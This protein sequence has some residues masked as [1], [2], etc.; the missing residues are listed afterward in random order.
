MPSQIEIII[1]AVDKASAQIK[2]ISKQINNQSGDTKDLIKSFAGLAAGMGAVIGVGSMV[3]KTLVGAANEA[4]DYALAMNDLAKI[5]GMSV[6]ETSRLVQVADDYRIEAGAVANAMA[7]MVKKGFEPSIGALADLADKYRSIEDPNERAAELTKLLGRNW[8]ALIPLLEAGGDAIRENAKAIDESLVVTQ[9]SVNQAIEYKRA[10]DELNDTWLGLKVSVGSE[11]VPA[12]TSLVSAMNNVV[13]ATKEGQKAGLEARR[14][15]VEKTTASIRGNKEALDGLSQAEKEATETR[16]DEADAAKQLSDAVTDLTDVQ[17]SAI[18]MYEMQVHGIYNMIEAQ[19]DYAKSAQAAEDITRGNQAALKA[20]T[21]SLNE[22]NSAYMAMLG[23]QDTL[24][25]AMDEWSKT[26]GADAA[27]ALQDAGLSGERYRDA[28]AIIDEVLGTQ[29]GMQQDYND[30]LAELAEQ[31]AQGSLA[32]EDFRAQ[33]AAIR[34]EFAPLSERV[35]EAQERLNTLTSAFNYINGRH[36]TAYVDVIAT[37]REAGVG[38]GGSA[39]GS[40]PPGK[41]AGGGPV[42]AGVSYIVGE[43]GTELFVPASSGRI[44]PSSAGGGGT[45]IVNQYNYTAAAAALSNALVRQARMSGLNRSMG[46]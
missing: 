3:A 40:H 38:G 25:A 43:Q 12:L 37:L 8:T 26:V 13:E 4:A 46:G 36:F 29:L 9:E 44:M 15:A 21:D 33:L 5:T 20:Y 45:V 2:N 6:E 39:P 24:K 16:L 17:L 22:V 30:R 10:L 41:R 11:V 28:L 18:G 31:Y 14:E 23:A 34:D 35:Q 7:M 27:G 32:G 1:R 42:Y 19:D